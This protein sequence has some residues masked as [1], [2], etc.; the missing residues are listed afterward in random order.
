MK[1]QAIFPTSSVLG[2]TEQSA[3]QVQTKAATRLAY[4]DSIRIFLTI[5]VV[6]HHLM[7]IYSGSGGWLYK[8]GR[9]DIFTAAMGG[10]FTS[11]NHSYF[12]GLFLLISAYFVPGSYDRK[13]PA[14]FVKDRLV[15]LGIPLAIYCWV[16]RP[17]L[18][19]AGGSL[20]GGMGLSFP[21]W[22]VNEY[23]RDYGL[24]GG[25][26]SWFIEA[27]LLFSLLYVLWRVLIPSHPR[28]SA[29][30]TSFP[31]HLA[32]ALFALLLAVASFIVR[33]WFP[34][35][36][37]FS[38][39]NFQLADFSQYISLFILGLVA[40]Q[41]NWFEG[42][43][44]KTGKTWL[45]VGLVLILAYPPIAILGGAIENSA[46]FKG[47][48]HWQAMMTAMWQSYLC[49]SM[50]IS[51]IYI[52]RRRFNRQGVLSGFLSHN[53]YTVYLIHEPV[54]IFVAMGLTGLML[55]PLLKFGL[56]ALITIPLCFGL[57]SLIRKLPYTQ[58][59]L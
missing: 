5:L 33:L 1:T 13:G 35:D 57:S 39:L 55:Y 25:G 28:E 11:V 14:R 46:P 22:Y 32:I 29:P 8:E 21:S 50:C 41:R 17:I 44:E 4:I 3:V 58:R 18:I 20:S 15:R 56:V 19:Y 49:V 52:S 2:V 47:G 59:V 30:K 24:I 7:I 34:A 31:S 23:F 10:W 6:L 27:L 45:I 12:M 9:Q 36:S 40:Y 51:V 38:P 37:V 53:A 42:L 48:W 26:P 54:I 43:P 16:L